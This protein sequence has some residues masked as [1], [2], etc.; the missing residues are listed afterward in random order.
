LEATKVREAKGG[1]GELGKRSRCPYGSPDNRGG[2]V[3]RGGTRTEMQNE[4]VKNV[5][6]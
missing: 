5:Y 1:G 4:K 2:G 6:L 3:N